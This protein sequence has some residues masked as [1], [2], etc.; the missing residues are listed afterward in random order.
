MNKPI[1]IIGH[2]LAGCTLGLTCLKRQIPFQMIGY[3][4][5]GEASIVSSGLIAP[6]T[7]RRYVKA[8]Q[9]DDF[10]AKALDFYRWSESLVGETYFFPVEIVRFLSNDEAR[11]AW[12][13]RMLDAEYAAYISNCKYDILDEFQKP[14]GILTGGYR[15]DTPGWIGA[16]RNL[17]QTRGFL[18]IHSSLLDVHST[19]ENSIIYATGAIDPSLA[20]GII[21]N[22]GEALIVSMPEW[23]YP[24]IIK[25]EVYVIPLQKRGTYWV[26]SYYIPGE[27]N[28]MPSTLGREQLLGSIRKMYKG[29]LEVL[30]HM[31]G[32]RP[33]VDDRRPIVGPFPNR[34]NEYLFNG[35]GTKGTSLA[36]FWAEQLLSHILNDLPLPKEVL[37]A[38]YL[39]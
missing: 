11:K 7:G 30:S 32:I 15:L 39:K 27:T 35:M 12:N 17:L 19:L 1:L 2:G 10:I 23:K 5:S 16:V 24:Q 31:A 28:P 29:S 26:G 13:K 25:D 38:R 37:P 18:K 4:Q 22:K 6:V 36:P 33:T 21:P 34:P 8:W 20:H 14:Y 9:I 3:A